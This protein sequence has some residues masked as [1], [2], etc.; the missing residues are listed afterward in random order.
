MKHDDFEILLGHINRL[1]IREWSVESPLPEFLSAMNREQKI[2]FAVDLALLPRLYGEEYDNV[3][4]ALLEAYL[5]SHAGKRALMDLGWLE[6]NI[7][8]VH[9]TGKT[10]SSV[11][12][13]SDGLQEDMV[14]KVLVPQVEQPSQTLCTPYL[15]PGKETDPVKLIGGRLSAI[16]FKT[17]LESSRNLGENGKLLPSGARSRDSQ[18]SELLVNLLEDPGDH[19]FLE[20]QEVQTYLI[21]PVR[22]DALTFLQLLG[23]EGLTDQEWTRSLMQ[24]LKDRILHVLVA[25]CIAHERIQTEDSKADEF[26]SFFQNPQIKRSPIEANLD[27]LFLDDAE[28]SL[29]CI[30]YCLGEITPEIAGRKV[31]ATW[32]SSEFYHALGLVSERKLTPRAKHLLN[33]LEAFIDDS[34]PNSAARHNWQDTALTKPEL[35]E[36]IKTRVVEAQKGEFTEFCNLIHLLFRSDNRP[37]RKI[38]AQHRLRLGIHLFLRYSEAIPRHLLAFPLTHTGRSTELNGRIAAYFLGTITDVYEDSQPVR[39]DLQIRQM[40]LF[41]EQIFTAACIQLYISHE[42]GLAKLREHWASDLAKASF[43]FAHEAKHRA[44]DA[45]ANIHIANLQK[46]LD[47]PSDWLTDDLR[48][49]IGGMIGSFTLIQELYGISELISEVNKKISHNQSPGLPMTWVKKNY[50]ATAMAWPSP[51]ERDP[52]AFLAALVNSCRLRIQT[53]IYPHQIKA[54]S[55][56]FQLELSEITA[57]TLERRETVLIQDDSAAYCIPPLDDYEKNRGPT[58]ALLAGIAEHA[59]N[60]ASYLIS[61]AAPIRQKSKTNVL[62]IDFQI[63]VGDDHSVEVSIWNP[64]RKP[65]YS[66]TIEIMPFVY[67]LLIGNGEAVEVAQPIVAEHPTRGSAQFK[68]CQSSVVI[69]PQMFKFV[70]NEADKDSEQESW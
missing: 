23:V 52:G 11:R 41:C 67:K 17:R 4:Y 2:D 30:D 10:S 18:L 55:I 24:T 14:R 36:A 13:K 28:I 62:Y 53:A 31:K 48:R 3:A 70:S 46:I 69:R 12:P 29:A 19:R 9:F 5:W 58:L 63:K 68:H 32:D 26:V 27:V 7:V 25:E 60:A 47:T 22:K 34:E 50:R 49:Q 44:N 61:E 43:V 6:G 8:I 45:A 59:R 56:G 65:P 21:D 51:L 1:R 38:E 66:R 54:E 15:W 57:G 40:K 37:R 64:C 20:S 35:R 33:W 39:R 42:Y 16:P